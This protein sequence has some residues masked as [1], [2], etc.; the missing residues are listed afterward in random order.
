MESFSKILKF[1]QVNPAIKQELEQ[2]GIEFV[3]GPAL[4]VDL[5]HG[6]QLS[7]SQRF[8]AEADNESGYSEDSS[9][10]ALCQNGNLTYVSAWGYEDVCRFPTSKALVEEILRLKKT[11]AENPIPPEDKE[12]DSEDAETDKESAA[13]EGSTKEEDSEEEK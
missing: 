4:R 12:S 5:G 2:H 13:T 3:G 1:N 6:Y 11:I 9:E 8:L 10:T 7:V